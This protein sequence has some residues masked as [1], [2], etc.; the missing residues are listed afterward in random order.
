MEHSMEQQHMRTG[1]ASDS[2]SPPPQRLLQVGTCSSIVTG[3]PFP[4]L[5]TLL[6]L[7]S[8]LLSCPPRP[9]QESTPTA[10]QAV[11]QHTEVFRV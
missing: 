6:T 10:C 9:Y 1:G 8:A 7:P 5:I 3:N 4:S 11:T 2:T